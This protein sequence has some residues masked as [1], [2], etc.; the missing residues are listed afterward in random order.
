MA[1]NRPSM[2]DVNKATS[3]VAGQQATATA[4]NVPA[5]QQGGKLAVQQ[6]EDNYDLSD[7][8]LAM[9]NEANEEN[10]SASEIQISRLAV[11]QKNSPE[12]ENNNPEYKDGM[13]VDNKSRA[14]YST[15]GPPPWLTEKGIDPS[16]IEGVHY[17][18]F[19]PIFKLPNEFIHWKNRTTEGKGMHFKTLD[20]NDARVKAGCFPPFGHW[21]PDPSSP[22]KASP[23]TNNINYLGVLV[24]AE[25][26]PI[27]EYIISTFAKGN[28][29]VGKKITTALQ[30]V[31][32][33]RKPYWSLCVGL[34]TWWNKTEKGSYHALEAAIIKQQPRTPHVLKMCKDIA[35]FLGDKTQGVARQE[36][37]LNAAEPEQ[38]DDT[39][40]FDAATAAA[41]GGGYTEENEASTEPKF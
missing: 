22:I 17:V 31:K 34:Y 30:Y 3:E 26:N 10:T 23:V 36:A 7:E 14:I 11:M 20:P 12:C 25:G 32:G 9:L 6:S 2:D 35:L 4:A 8:E 5:V 29:N 18:R 15:F 21:K 40:T 1:L 27:S 39:Q 13:L 28:T 16:T 19:L 24:D 41:G 33:N 37:F 38:D